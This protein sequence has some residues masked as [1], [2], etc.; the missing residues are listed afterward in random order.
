M[1]CSFSGLSPHF[2]SASATLLFLISHAAYRQSV[3]PSSWQVIDTKFGSG[4]SASDPLRE[5]ETAQVIQG[6]VRDSD[7]GVIVFPEMV[8]HRWNDA[9]KAFWEPTLIHLRQA[10]MTILLG[11]G[12]SLPGRP[13]SYLNAAVI[14]GSH[15]ASPFIQR[16][17]VPIAMWKPFSRVDGVP[18]RLLG[19]G[20]AIVADQRAAILICY[21]QLLA[22]PFF[23]SAMEHPSVLI[24]MANDYWAAETA[25][26]A[27][28]NACLHAWA[29]LFRLPYVSAMNT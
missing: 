1:V 9:A 26:P 8:V 25:I 21:E 10:D 12:L 23:A 11:A 6:I 7:R 14:L 3:P 4:F 15:P 16:I 29:R 28:Q 2:V 27:V 24:G 13:Q 18:L 22:W 5:F 19:A 20:T 17:P